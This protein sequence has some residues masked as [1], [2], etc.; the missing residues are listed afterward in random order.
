M[1]RILLAGLSHETHCFVNGTT[2]LA[3]FDIVRG[4]AILDFAGNGSTIDGF[5]EVAAAQGWDVEPACAYAASPSAMVD[6]AVIE[7]FWADLEPVARRGPYDAVY[8]NLHGAM[9]SQSLTDVEGTILERLRGI[10]GLAGVPIFGV[11]D[12]HA[13]MTALMARHANG[14]VCYRENPHI[15]AR[16]SAVRAAEL[17]ARCLNEGTVPRMVGRH[18]GIVW[19]P[20]G[21]GTAEAPMQDLEV[22]AR[23]IEEDSE[24]IWAVNVVGG[25]SFADVPEAGVAF[26]VITT[27]DHAEAEEALDALCD[28]AWELRA[29]GLPEEDDPASVLERLAADPPSGPAI[30]VEPS[31]NVSGGAP[32]NGTGVLRALLAADAQNAGVVIADA[33][34]VGEL[35]ELAP[36]E[37]KTVAIGGKNNPFDPGPIELDV[38]LVSRSDGNFTLE[39]IKSH[40]VAARGKHIAMGPSAVVRHRGITILLNS[41][42]TPPF[43]LGQ[44]RSQGIDPEKL[45]V[46]GVKAA[47]AHRR[48]YDKIA[49]ASFTVETQGPCISD[50]RKLPYTRLQRPIYPLDES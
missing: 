45:S 16:D 19:P 14:L 5:L 33:E 13:N 3:D 34:A 22:L 47:V 20:T 9:V 8:L 6:D 1:S 4:S 32:G 49:A 42:K 41:R 36:G 15:D 18:A 21:T 26:S 48:A 7:A 38:E 12:L 44:W 10:D 39:D 30:L 37:H 25:F 40:M 46:I 23:R 27:G 29:Q 11:F 43:D 28:K 50:P 31:D 2:G 24:H 17:L 35:E